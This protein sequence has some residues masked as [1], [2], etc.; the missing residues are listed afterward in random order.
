MIRRELRQSEGRV[1]MKINSAQIRLTPYHKHRVTTTR[2]R[3]IAKAK[4]S[5][6]KYICPICKLPIMCS[7]VCELAHVVPF[8]LEHDAFPHILYYTHKECNRKLGEK[9]LVIDGLD[10]QKLISVK[11]GF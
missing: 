7:D 2:H 4:A 10:T 9:V 5:T 6:G 3:E 1:I 8:S 11:V